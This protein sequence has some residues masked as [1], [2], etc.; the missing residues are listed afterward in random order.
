[1]AGPKRIV[2]QRDL[3]TSATKD[4][5]GVTFD[6]W[7]SSRLAMIQFRDNSDLHHRVGQLTRRTRLF[8]AERCDHLSN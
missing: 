7:L 1:M 4:R 6:R 2:M 5:R 3:A 8:K